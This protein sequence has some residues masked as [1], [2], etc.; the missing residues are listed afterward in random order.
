MERELGAGSLECKE[1]VAV[2][3]FKT[4]S[5]DW[6][7]LYRLK[8]KIATVLYCF[9]MNG[10]RK[11]NPKKGERIKVRGLVMQREGVVPQNFPSHIIKKLPNQVSRFPKGCTVQ[12]S[13]IQSKLGFGFWSRKVIMILWSNWGKPPQKSLCWPCCCVPKLMLKPLSDSWRSEERRVG[14]ECRSRWSPYH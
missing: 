6:L 12:R 1:I 8:I 13:P 3:M 4:K 11:N 7:D 5:L 10:K 9:Q 14:K 2:E